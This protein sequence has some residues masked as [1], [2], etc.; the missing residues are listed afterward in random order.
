MQRQRSFS[1]KSLLRVFL[2]LLLRVWTSLSTQSPKNLHSLTSP[3]N[4]AYVIYTSGSTGKPKGTQ[5][6]CKGVVNCIYSLKKLVNVNKN[7]TFFALTSISFDVA[8]MDYYLPFSVG[9]RVIIAS[10]NDQ[11]DAL[12]L[13]DIIKRQSIDCIQGTPSL[14][15]MLISSLNYD[16]L[17]N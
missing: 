16:L 3:H 6:N 13:N 11:K 1:L 9:A 2:A 4:L 8:A 12:A 10:Q 5:V 15:Q 7:H 17:I 14:F